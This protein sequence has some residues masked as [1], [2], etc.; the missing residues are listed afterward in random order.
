MGVA[1]LSEDIGRDN[2]RTGKMFLVEEAAYANGRTWYNWFTVKLKESSKPRVLQLQVKV[3][4]WRAI[5][6][7][8]AAE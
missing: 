5:E 3:W 6:C 1:G 4:Q 8:K 7:F 2:R